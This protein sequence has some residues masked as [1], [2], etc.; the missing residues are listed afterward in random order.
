MGKSVFQDFTFNLRLLT[1]PKKADGVQVTGVVVARHSDFKSDFEAPE[2]KEAKHKAH[3]QKSRL[4]F[5]T[6]LR[7]GW[8]L[9]TGSSALEV[10]KSK[11][12]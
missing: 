10:S 11:P 12:P 9:K 7:A 2:A 3:L 4:G 8:S 6:A 5:L 1:A